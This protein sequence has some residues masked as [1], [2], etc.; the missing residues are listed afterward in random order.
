MEHQQAHG[1]TKQQLLSWNRNASKSLKP[2]QVLKLQTNALSARKGRA[3][4]VRRGDSLSSIAQQ[5]EVSV[6]DLVRWNS[7]GNRHSLKPGQKLVI[8][9]KR[10]GA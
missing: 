9:E 5:F 3:Y 4:E 10:S 2:G 8:N 6:D 7:L 1:I